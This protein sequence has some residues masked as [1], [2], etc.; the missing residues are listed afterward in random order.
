MVRHYFIAAIRNMAA[1][2]LQSA[3][4][5]LGLAV[6]IAAAILMALAVRNQ[7]SFDHFFPGYERTY[8]VAAEMP[9]GDPSAR[10]LGDST[11][12]RMADLIRLKAPGVE[13]VTRLFTGTSAWIK[14]GQTIAREGIIWGD[15]NMFAVL[16]FPVAYGD[17]ATALHRPGSVVLSRSMAEKYFGRDDVVGQT[18]NLND[19]PMTVQA[20]IED[21]PQNATGFSK[22][23][24]ASDISPISPLVTDGPIAKGRIKYNENTYL[25]LKPGASA[26]GVEKVIRPLFESLAHGAGKDATLIRLDQ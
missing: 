21:F 13:S 6:G 7:L 2:K 25:R 24:Y 26:A 8:L 15:P 5:I 1:N 3:I 16:P 10:I 11:D 12:P 9:L 20:V 22:L 14:H 18:I 19:H 23:I 4:A 17:P